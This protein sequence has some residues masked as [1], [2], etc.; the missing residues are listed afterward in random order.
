MSQIFTSALEPTPIITPKDWEDSP[1]FAS[2]AYEQGFKNPWNPMGKPS[3]ADLLRWRT[4]KSP[5]KEQKGGELPP[6]LVSDPLGGFKASPQA[7]K[8][9]WAGHASALIELDG[10]RCLI[11]PVFGSAAVVRRKRPSPLEVKTLPHVH[12]ILLTHGHY[13][14]FEAKV[15]KQL[16]DRFGQDT[17]FIVPKGLGS[18]LPRSCQRI[19]E[20]SWWEY[21]KIDQVQ[22][23]LVPSQH[24]HR[25]GLRDYN[26]ALWGGWYL[27]G[28]QRIYHMGDSGY[29]GSFKA[30]RDTL[31][32]PDLAMLPLGAW[33]P[34]WF[35]GYQHMA[36]E[37][38]L[39]TWD[40][41]GA[42]HMVA[43]HWG[44]FDL[45]DEP[46]DLGPTYF[47][48]LLQE[49]E[50]PELAERFFALQLGATIGVDEHEAHVEGGLF[51]GH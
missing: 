36:P 5:W 1:I 14:H 47:R 35:M 19:V 40:D 22:I 49:K 9:L 25:R 42:R 38:T 12:A 10:V 30:V 51:T 11:D 15:L 17:W 2:P 48:E 26:A 33:E 34:R 7:A 43:M 4:G 24:W 31:G 45:A 20:L 37:Q 28:T 6:N 21:V 44:V 39:Q 13:D 16:G 27:S 8:L 18:Y 23:T 50:R 29:F 32:A 41:L 46:V 3:P